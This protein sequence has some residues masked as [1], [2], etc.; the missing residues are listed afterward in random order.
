MF[1]LG[2]RCPVCE[3]ELCVSAG[4]GVKGGVV[5]TIEAEPFDSCSGGSVAVCGGIDVSSE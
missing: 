4:V 3:D 2:E 1:W 5:G